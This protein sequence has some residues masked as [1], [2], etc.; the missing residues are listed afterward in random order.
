MN[1][2]QIINECNE[3]TSFINECNRIRNST[4]DSDLVVLAIAAHDKAIRARATLLKAYLKWEA[5]NE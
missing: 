3:I 2:Q 1:K 4:D 5:N